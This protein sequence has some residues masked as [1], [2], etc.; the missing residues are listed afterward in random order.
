MHRMSLQEWQERNTPRVSKATA[1]AQYITRV[2]RE[3][4]KRLLA[5]GYITKRPAKVKKRWQFT[6]GGADVETA[7]F[8]NAH[9]RSEARCEIK[10][11][12]NVKHLP[13]GIHITEVTANELPDD[14]R[15]AGAA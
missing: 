13:L 8:V 4:V 14:Q 5:G 7:G 6:L 3:V 11:V 10:R 2:R 1:K 12:L 9:T 15:I